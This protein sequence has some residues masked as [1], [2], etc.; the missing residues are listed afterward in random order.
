MSASGMRLRAK[1]RWL[2]GASFECKFVSDGFAKSISG[3]KDFVSFYNW[4]FYQDIIGP[5]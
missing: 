4:D 2:V 1:E 5:V 3:N